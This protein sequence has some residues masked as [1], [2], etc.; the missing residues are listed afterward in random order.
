[1]KINIKHKNLFKVIHVNILQFFTVV[2]TN[3]VRHPIN[4]N[5]KLAVTTFESR[6]NEVKVIGKCFGMF[7]GK[8]VELNGLSS[9]CSM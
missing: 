4:L 9:E 3:K 7:F 5:I 8:N 2:Q 6:F 1:M